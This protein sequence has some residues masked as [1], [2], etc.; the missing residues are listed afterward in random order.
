LGVQ[1]RK[2]RQK[3]FLRQEILD[4][5]S[6]LFVKEGYENVSMRRIADKIEYSPTT[7]YLYFKDKAELLEQVCQETFS[8]LSQ[9][10][11]RILEQPGDPVE[12]LRRG[13]IAYVHFGLENPHHYRASFMMPSPEGFDESKYIQPDSPGIRAFDFLRRSVFDCIAAGKLR[14]KDAELISQTLWCGTH[15]VTSLLITHPVF[16]WVGKQEVIESVVDT[17]IAGLTK[18]CG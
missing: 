16:P 4:A 7:I 8:R 3:K 13:L 17:L 2:L 18:E 11:A 10:L 15:G 5:A 9:R 6:E 12:R 1:E 14:S